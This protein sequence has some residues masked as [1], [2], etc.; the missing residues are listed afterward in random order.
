MNKL[1]LFFCCFFPFFT[2]VTNAITLKVGETE[3]LDIGN[4]SYLQGCQWTIS[5][6]NDVVFVTT[7]QS[8]TTKVT[9]KAVNAFS[10]SPC[11]VQCKY[12]YLDLDPTTG[13]YTYLRTGY[14]DWNVFVKDDENGGGSSGGSSS[15]DSYISL[16]PSEIS[17][18]VGFG[19]EYVYATGT[20]SGNLTWSID[21]MG[22]IAS[23]AEM[24]N[25]QVWC[26]GHTVGITYLRAT[27]SNGKQAVCKINVVPKGSTLINNIKV[28]NKSDID[29]Y[30]N[31]Q[32]QRVASPQRGSIYIK[33]GKKIIYP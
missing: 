17:V 5:R 23:F 30:Y 6:P 18:E 12:Y 27:C 33:N 4:V 32:G 19:S 9:I 16:K 14:K 8:Y 10:G 22:K 13:R 25:D 1:K 24:S 2:I 26:Y 11:V 20:Y 15:D 21:C 3:T 29:I 7:P 31:L 28:D